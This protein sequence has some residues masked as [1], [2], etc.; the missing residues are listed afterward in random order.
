MLDRFHTSEDGVLSLNVKYAARSSRLDPAVAP[1]VEWN[2]NRTLTDSGPAAGFTI[3]R[4]GR[5]AG[6][7]RPR[8]AGSRRRASG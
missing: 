5:E 8:P 1:E 4:C 2:V 3:V 6:R 7:A